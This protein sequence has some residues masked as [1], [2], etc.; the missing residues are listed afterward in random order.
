MAPGVPKD[1][2]GWLALQV[3]LELLVPQVAP[4]SRGLL[5]L[6]L[7]TMEMIPTIAERRAAVDLKG[8]KETKDPS[9]TASQAERAFQEQLGKVETLDPQ[10]HLETQEILR[11]L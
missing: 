7:L 5:D 3:P 11:A 10:D 1:N 8:I 9:S 6:Q 4:V 2:K